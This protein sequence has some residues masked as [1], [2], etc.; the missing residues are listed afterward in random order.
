VSLLFYICSSVL[1]T[2]YLYNYL[3][4]CFPAFNVEY[5]SDVVKAFSKAEAR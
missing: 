5:S 3:H 2:V 4:L 1:F